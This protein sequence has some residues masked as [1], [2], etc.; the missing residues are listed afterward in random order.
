MLK[1]KKDSRVVKSVGKVD[2]N[3][4]EKLNIIFIHDLKKK[5]G[6]IK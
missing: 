5:V 1:N 2:L 3:A 6:P 4:Y